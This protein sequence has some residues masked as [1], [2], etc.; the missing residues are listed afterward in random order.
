MP[1]AVIEACQIVDVEDLATDGCTVP[2]LRYGQAFQGAHFVFFTPGDLVGDAKVA[3]TMGAQ[4]EGVD[5][6]SGELGKPGFAGLAGLREIVRG[7]G[8]GVAIGGVEVKGSEGGI[9]RK[10]VGYGG[11]EGGAEGGVGFN[12][13][14]EAA[15]AFEDPKKERDGRQPELADHG[16][17]ESAAAANTFQGTADAHL[18]PI[19]I[20]ELGTG[21]EGFELGKPGEERTK[22]MSVEGGGC[23]YG[24]GHKKTNFYC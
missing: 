23:F 11:G 13:E 20:G 9:G 3:E 21:A 17:E 16:L 1:E 4:V 18:Q 6:A 14:G 2:E 10:G 22:K 8:M 12:A 5:V 24:N 19:V 15:F 7:G